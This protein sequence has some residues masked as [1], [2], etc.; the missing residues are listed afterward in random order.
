MLLETELSSAPSLKTERNLV[1]TSIAAMRILLGV[2]FV[3]SAIANLI[4]L[5]APGGLL[6]TALTLPLRLW[7]FGFEGIGP[8][9]P[10]IAYPYAFLLPPFQLIVGTLFVI[11]RQVR[12]AGIVMMLML[13]SFILAFGLVGPDG[14][15]PNNQANWDKNVFM[16]LGAWICTAYDHYGVQRKQKLNRI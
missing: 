12:W 1:R 6:E 9:P 4:Y 15:L 10:L 7:G 8:L 11:N 5:R 3:L 2:F 13:L 14:L 16:L